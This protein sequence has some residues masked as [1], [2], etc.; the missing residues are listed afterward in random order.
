YALV[1]DQGLAHPETLLEDRPTDFNGYAP[2]NFDRRTRGTIRARE[3]LQQSLNIP[4]VALTEA[5]GPARLMTA[6]RAAG[7]RPRL[8][9]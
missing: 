5:L 3:A 6:L 9:G 1:F 4:V 7:A 2:Q 8:P